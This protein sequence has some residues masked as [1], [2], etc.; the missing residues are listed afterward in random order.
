M[1]LSLEE[2]INKKNKRKNK[3][4]ENKIKKPKFSRKLSH[5]FNGRKWN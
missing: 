2:L 5:L 3:S 1:E 4:K